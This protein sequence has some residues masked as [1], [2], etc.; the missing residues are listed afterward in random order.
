MLPLKALFEEIGQ[1][2][3]D[4]GSQQEGMGEGNHK[5]RITFGK[6]I[7]LWTNEAKQ[8][9]HRTKC[10][11]YCAY[12]EWFHTTKNPFRT[13][14]LL[15]ISDNVLVYLFRIWVIQKQNLCTTQ[16]H[17]IMIQGFY[18]AHHFFTGHVPHMNFVYY[19]KEIHL[20]NLTRQSSAIS[21]IVRQLFW[22][23]ASIQS[24][25][26]IIDILLTKGL[27]SNDNITE[28]A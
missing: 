11:F 21:D 26:T 8:L 6:I 10:H 2:A 9:T 13:K 12:A 3:H 16:V 22:L 28:L 7:F 19:A 5:V 25:S 20:F 1:F 14:I 23:L 4:I 24:Y 17:F 27:Q 15:W 18:D